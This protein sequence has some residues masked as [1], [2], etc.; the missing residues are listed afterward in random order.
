MLLALTPEQADLQ[1]MLRRAFEDKLPSS[2]LRA[3]LSGDPE[4]WDLT[5]RLLGLHGL[6]VAEEHG[7]SSASAVE[8]LLLFEEAGRALVPGP[9]FS[10]VAL[11]GGLLLAAG[12][13]TWLPALADGSLRAAFAWCTSDLPSEPIGVAEQGAD[14]WVVSGTATAVLDGAEADLLVVVAEG[15]VLLAVTRDQATV[16]SEPLVTLDLTRPAATVRFDRAAGVL[17]AGPASAASVLRAGL[18]HAQLALA[19]EQVGG[20]QWCLDASVAHALVREQFGRPIGSFQAVKHKLADMHVRVELARSL[21]WYAA[22]HPDD[23]GW[24]AAAVSGCSEA[25]LKVAA[26]AIQVHGGIGFTWEHDAHLHYRRAR[27]D[28]AMLGSP[29]QARARLAEVIA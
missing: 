27:A 20:A 4:L 12:A 7:G 29:R 17:L 26:D 19:A 28:H 2:R 11:A 8:Q 25:Y 18:R 9:F 13:S 6:A 22:W 24:S 16:T 23:D 15:P 5:S 1:A 21:A 10:T 3:A 14:G